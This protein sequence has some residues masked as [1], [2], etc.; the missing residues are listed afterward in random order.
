MVVENYTDHQGS[1]YLS[2]NNSELEHQTVFKLT[3]NLR[4][5]EAVSIA[6]SSEL[7][8]R[9]LTIAMNLLKLHYTPT[10]NENSRLLL[11]KTLVQGEEFIT[12]SHS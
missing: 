6:I 11:A 3:K 4:T 2:W 1:E 12:A 10:V 5:G 8:P 9:Y 7:H